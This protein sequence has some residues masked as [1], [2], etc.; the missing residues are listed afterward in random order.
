MKERRREGGS[1]KIE[2]K[3]RGHRSQGTH[4]T[5]CELTCGIEEFTAVV[6][7]PGGLLSNLSLQ[8]THLISHLTWSLTELYVH[9]CTCVAT[10]MYSV[11]TYLQTHIQYTH[12]CTCTC[13]HV[14]L[15]VKL[16]CV[17]YVQYRKDHTLHVSSIGASERCT[18]NL[19]KTFLF[20]VISS[21]NS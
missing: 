9:A 12:V 13:V 16:L 14:C 17:L 6:G 10:C 11:C 5:E 3:R 7:V 8:L 20:A 15:T 21:F 19:I 4:V 2:I 18:T 1:G